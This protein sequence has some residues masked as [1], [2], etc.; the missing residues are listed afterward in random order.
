MHNIRRL[1]LALMLAAFAAVAALGAVAWAD[2]GDHTDRGMHVVGK[3]T[4]KS[5]DNATPQ[6]FD[7]KPLMDWRGNTNVTFTVDDKTKYFIYDKPGAGFGDLAV[8]D[9]VEVQAHKVTNNSVDTWVA[10]QV[11]VVP[12]MPAGGGRVTSITDN[13]FVIQAG[14]HFTATVTTNP[15]DPDKTIFRVPGVTGTPT[16]NDLKLGDWVSV[17]AKPKAT[18]ADDE[19]PTPKE[20]TAYVVQVVR[21]APPPPPAPTTHL[22]NE[23]GKI[24][25]LNKDAKSFDLVTDERGANN[26]ISVK[27]DDKTVVLPDGAEFKNDLR[28]RVVGTRTGTDPVTARIIVVEHEDN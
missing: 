4:A 24:A 25:N 22:F 12:P 10:D 11:T 8:N 9:K 21:R 2:T 3:I 1:T 5:A 20:I 15:S 17:W 16:I 26:T 7:V 6:T 14:E 27:W 18:S 28:V 23:D 19:H 13:K